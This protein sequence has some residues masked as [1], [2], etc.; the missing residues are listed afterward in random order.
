MSEKKDLTEQEKAEFVKKIK[1]D[2]IQNNL[3]YGKRYIISGYSWLVGGAIII[4]IILALKVVPVE[5]FLPL[6]LLTWLE[7]TIFDLF[8]GYK[9]SIRAVKD[10]SSGKIS[11]LEYK[12]LLKSG[13]LEKWAK[14]DDELKSSNSSNEVVQEKKEKQNKEESQKQEQEGVTFTAEEVALLKKLMDKK[15]INNVEGVEKP[16]NSSTPK[17]N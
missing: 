9:S 13:E 3:Q 15:I 2:R 6:A 10:A 4:G 17:D 1:S 12:R 14:Y 7:C 8:R 16:E 5:F 11:Y